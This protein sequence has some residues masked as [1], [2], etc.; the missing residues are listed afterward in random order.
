M[1]SRSAPAADLLDRLDRGDA[2]FRRDPW[3]VY[4]AARATTPVAWAPGLRAVVAF[5]YHD[6]RRALASHD[7]VAD[8]PFR[9]SRRAFGAT[10]LDTEG[11]AHRR[12]RVILSGPLRPAASGPGAASPAAAVTAAEA[13]VAGL[14]ARGPVDLVEDVARVLP[15][16]VACELLGL[17]PA[18]APGLA[19]TIAPLVAYIDDGQAALADVRSARMAADEVLAAVLDEGPGPVP[20]GSVAGSVAGSAPLRRALVEARERGTLSAAEVRRNAVLLLVAATATTARALANVLSAL[21][22]G[23][24][25]R[26]FDRLRAGTLDPAA[27]VRETLRRDPPLHFTPRF[28]ATDTRVGGVDVPRGTAVQL[29]LASANRDAGAFA[30]PD[31]WDPQRAQSVPALTFGTGRHG[32]LGGSLGTRELEATVAA[33]ARRYARLVPT[34][35]PPP[36]EGWMLRGPARLLVEVGERG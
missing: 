36:A 22:E 14:P 28:A 16:R 7:L 12:C 17:P 8:S 15:M 4:A 24:A 19:A 11:D 35:A 23:P 31:E 18:C 2:G 29:C 33:L 10:V 30:R 20:A 1:T 34:E 3:P 32:C 6:V 9:A 21:V 13:V 27:V 26:P 5:R 25:P